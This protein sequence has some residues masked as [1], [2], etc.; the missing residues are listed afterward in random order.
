MRIRSRREE[1]QV[2]P[3]LLLAVIGGFAIAV[4]FI[5]LQNLL[6]QTGRADSAADSAALAAAEAHRDQ[7]K[8]EKGLPSTPITRLTVWLNA[9]RKGK[10]FIAQGAAQNLATANGADLE[11]FRYRFQGRPGR[12]RAVYTVVTRQQDTVKGGDATAN[13]R[14][15]ATA[16]AEISNSVGGEVCGVFPFLGVD[17]GDGQ[18]HVELEWTT[19]C[20]PSTTPPPPEWCAFPL[21]KIEWKVHL[22]KNGKSPF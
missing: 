18:C 20:I 12:Y 6:D 1:G 9:I 8:I 3:A 4:S 17:F 16:I 5:P 19:R 13:S 21:P 22:I 7:Y 14:S 15:R 2:Y 10:G 11:S